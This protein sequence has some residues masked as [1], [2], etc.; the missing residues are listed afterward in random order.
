MSHI[1]TIEMSGDY[2][3]LM[4]ILQSSED[5]VSPKSREHLAKQAFPDGDP[6]ENIQKV[7][8]VSGYYEGIPLVSANNTMRCLIN[9]GEFLP[10][11]VS[12]PLYGE[13][14]ALIYLNV[15]KERLEEPSKSE[16]GKII[17]KYGN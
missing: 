5:Y 11:N 10:E 16:L 4:K 1:S 12:H 15:V 14:L 17:D 6:L 8:N 9:N 3:P 7:L 13:Q 2:N